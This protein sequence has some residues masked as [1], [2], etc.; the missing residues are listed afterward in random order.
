VALPNLPIYQ[1]GRTSSE[2]PVATRFQREILSLPMYPELTNEQ[3][4]FVCEHI[5]NFNANQ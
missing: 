1:D 4:A 3:I 5:L 2:F